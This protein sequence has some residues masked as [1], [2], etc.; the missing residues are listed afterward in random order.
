[1]PKNLK[2]KHWEAIDYKH[3]KRKRNGK[4]S[5]VLV[6]GVRLPKD[7]V[8]KQVSQQGV[9]T[10]METYRGVQDSTSPLDLISNTNTYKHKVLNCH[11]GCLSEHQLNEAPHHFKAPIMNRLARLGRIPR[12]FRA[13]VLMVLR[14][15]DNPT[16]N[17]STP[18]LTHAQIYCSFRSLLAVAIST[19]SIYFKTIVEAICTD[20]NPVTSGAATQWAEEILGNPQGTQIAE[21]PH[22]TVTGDPFSSNACKEKQP[23]LWMC[24][25]HCEGRFLDFQVQWIRLRES[26]KLYT[27]YFVM[28]HHGKSFRSFGYCVEIGLNSRHS[29][30]FLYGPRAFTWLYEPATLAAW[31]SDVE[32]LQKLFSAGHATPWDMDGKMMLL[33]AVRIY[34]APVVHVGH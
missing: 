34:F 11:I 3:K 6:H 2:R 24:H 22:D 13:L 16:V 23:H 17:W 5:E 10:A 25:C 26:E 1:V 4:E 18:R 12:Y 31:N 29:S 21:F 15:S 9:F 33:I 30:H 19:N 27:R 8:T 20:L 14:V 7:K 32:T 28:S